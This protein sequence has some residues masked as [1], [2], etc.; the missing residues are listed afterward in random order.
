MMYST[1]LPILYSFRRCPY[2]MR[3][4]MA[5]LKSGVSVELREV[6][7]RDKPKHLLAISAK[8]TVPVLLLP[9]GRVF[10]E[11]WQ[12]M[13][14][15]L[16]QH[17]PDLWLHEANRACVETLL[18]ENDHDFKAKLD[19]YKYAV[20]HPEQTVETYRQAG[21]VFLERLERNLQQQPFLCGDAI[22]VADIALMP[23]VRQFAHVDKAWFDHSPYPMLQ[24]WLAYFLQ[25]PLFVACMQKYPVWHVGDTAATFGDAFP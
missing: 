7:L 2:A 25:S 19:L 13:L 1:D 18:Q 8:A 16:Q 9:D 15:A 24:Q 10:D 6:L 3:A 12:I 5:I 21:E 23:F 22:S 11:S 14:W 20:R 17:D 4:R